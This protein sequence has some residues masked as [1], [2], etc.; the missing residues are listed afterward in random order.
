MQSAS[1][2]ASPVENRPQRLARGPI[3]PSPRRDVVMAPAAVAF[4]VEPRQFGNRANQDLKRMAARLDAQNR[5][6]AAIRGI[7]QAYEDQREGVPAVAAEVE[8]DEDYDDEPIVL[9]IQRS[10]GGGGGA[11][12]GAN[13]R[14]RTQRPNASCEQTSERA[15]RKQQLKQQSI[16][17]QAQ[18]FGSL[19]ECKIAFA[20]NSGRPNGKIP[21]VKQDLVLVDPDTVYYNKSNGGRQYWS[22]RQYNSFLEC[23]YH[24]DLVDNEASREL[25]ERRRQHQLAKSLNNSPFLK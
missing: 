16:R 1:R 24:P 6:L 15:R 19:P 12:G 2:R 7:R 21:T 11:G 8:G 14:Q 10:R 20:R 23:K 22:T 5:G 18:S 17:E 25:Y 3:I 4:P 13:Q 9:P